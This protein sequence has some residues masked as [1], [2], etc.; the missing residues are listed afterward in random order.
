MIFLKTGKSRSLV[1]FLFSHAFPLTEGALV[2]VLFVGFVSLKASCLR[3][4]E[5]CSGQE[6]AGTFCDLQS[7]KDWRQLKESQGPEGG[8]D[9]C[10]SAVGYKGEAGRREETEDF[11]L[12]WEPLPHRVLAGGR[13]RPHLIF[14]PFQ[15]WQP[16]GS[17]S[18]LPTLS[19]GET[20]LGAMF[21]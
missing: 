21:S 1:V 20:P 7:S 19:P 8:G 17:F 6:L 9:S 3:C 10:L 13:W 18:V 14:T 2:F 5:M 16:L 4:G 15:S 11:K 12:C